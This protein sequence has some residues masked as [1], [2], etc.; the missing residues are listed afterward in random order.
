MFVKEKVSG[1]SADAH[2]LSSL[3]SLRNCK[4]RVF[5]FVKKITS[6]EIKAAEWR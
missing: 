1:N 5:V 3:V 4:S 2:L 6:K